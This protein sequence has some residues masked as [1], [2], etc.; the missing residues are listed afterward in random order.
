MPVRWPP[1]AGLTIIFMDA[2]LWSFGGQ[3]SPLYHF[4]PRPFPVNPMQLLLPWGCDRYILLAIHPSIH[5]FICLDSF[6]SNVG[7]ERL[8]KK[9]KENW[10]IQN[11]TNDNSI[12]LAARTSSCSWNSAL[13]GGSTTVARSGGVKRGWQ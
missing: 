3:K 9:R 10:K 6:I 2:D 8:L 13:R 5:V 4:S 11:G 1:S 7:H 12:F